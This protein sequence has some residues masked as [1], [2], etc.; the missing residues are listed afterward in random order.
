[1]IN[2]HMD[3]IIDHITGYLS[4]FL[5]TST[6]RCFFWCQ[7]DSSGTVAFIAGHTTG[8]LDGKTSNGLNDI[9]IKKFQASKRLQPLI[10][11]GV[12]F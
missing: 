6:C 9:F 8:D 4:T 3:H 12:S 11:F 1:M 7:V 5:N 10:W 2:I